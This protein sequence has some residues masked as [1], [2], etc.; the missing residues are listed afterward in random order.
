MNPCTAHNY[1]LSEENGVPH[2]FS[3]RY[4]E[5]KRALIAEVAR[6]AQEGAPSRAARVASSAPRNE[7]RPRRVEGPNAARNLSWKIA[8]AVAAVCV[9]LPVGAYAAAN[10]EEVFA[11]MFGD[12]VRQSTSQQT[13]TFD[14][15]D[16]QTHSAIVPSRDYVA[17][18]P[19]VA[20]RV[21][22][23]ALADAPQ[24]IDAGSRQLT[25]TSVVRSEHQ[26]V[27]AYVLK[28]DPAAPTLSWDAHS[29]ATK[30]ACFADG[31][32]LRWQYRTTAVGSAAA[33]LLSGGEGTAAEA[34]ADGL[35]TVAPA[36]GSEAAAEQPSS[37]QAA[38]SD[39]GDY[40]VIGSSLYVDPERSTADTL[41]CYDYLVFPDG[42]PADAD[43]TLTATWADGTVAD[44]DASAVETKTVTL[45]TPSLASST[46]LATADDQQLSLSPLGLVFDMTAV[47]DQDSS[48]D[49]WCVKAITVHYQDGTS[50]EVWNGDE[51]RENSMYALGA[52]TNLDVAFNRL[53]DPAAVESVEV[54]NREGASTVFN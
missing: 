32:Q 6:G 15:G 42:I 14:K 31:A 10:H 22:G 26:M 45:A 41:Y 36:S 37:G 52:N 18:D 7:W 11:A 47:A 9:A 4:E 51:N 49:P 20:E 27:V 33:G 21:L 50:Y 2:K 16:G 54:I 23:G 48:R 25:I 19:E 12:A 30:G 40:A 24:V 53:V 1:D 5:R 38:P 8:A 39:A 28:D 34:S 13:V 35:A 29:N 44:A 17:V 43:I 46:T 3:A